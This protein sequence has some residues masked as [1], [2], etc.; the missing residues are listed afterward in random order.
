MSR[1]SAFELAI[2]EQSILIRTEHKKSQSYIAML[3]DVSDGYIGHVENPHRGEMYTHDQINAIALDL[4]ISP[5]LFYPENTV[6]QILPKKDPKQSLAKANAIKEKL[7]SMI[8]DD[9]FKIEKSVKQIIDEIT[10]DEEFI[11]EKLT[12]KDITDQARPL[13]KLDMLRS[14]KVSNKNFYINVI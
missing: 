3:L 11:N 1:K 5:Q 7:I 14:T 10:K 6:Q 2:V 9:F 12:N 13:V 4:N 8:D